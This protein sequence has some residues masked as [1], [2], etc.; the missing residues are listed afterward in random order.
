MLLERIYDEDLAQAS[1]V[2]GCQAKGEA[3]VVDPRRDIQVY[4]DL[5][6][7]HGMRITHVT[8]T[9]IH[10]DYLSGTRELAH[11]TGAQ[12]HLSGEGGEDWAY[13]FEG[14]L[15][16]DGD[17]V[18]L[19]NITVEAVHTP[20]HTPEHLSFLVTDGAFADAPGYMLTGDFVFSGDLGRP[21]L[22]DEAATARLRAGIAGAIPRAVKVV[23]ARDGKLDPAIL[24][25]LGAAAEDDLAA[26]PSHHDAEDG[27]HEHDDFTS[28]ALPLPELASPEALVERLRAVAEAHDVL[29]MKGFAAIAGKPLRLAVQGVGTRFSH[30]FDRAWAPGEARQGQLV[31][32]GQTGLD[33]DAIAAALMV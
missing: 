6:A 9:H 5:A 16:K 33:R 32:I 2:I 8:E 30:Q 19:G 25:G 18:T 29:R 21:D 1:Y 7:R 3:I 4:L 27:A 20:G 26:R 17:T 23:P 14:N 15:L 28:F 24:L 22:L 10:A 12:I 31:V 11:A 13:G